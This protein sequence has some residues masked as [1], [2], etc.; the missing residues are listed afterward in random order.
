MHAYIYVYIPLMGG[1]VNAPEWQ[2]YKGSERMHTQA[3]YNKRLPCNGSAGAA[4]AKCT[5]QPAYA[6]VAAQARATCLAVELGRCCTR[7]G[8]GSTDMGCRGL[9]SR[10]MHPAPQ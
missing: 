7:T 3:V 2:G 9:A 1:A 10:Q 5:L 4:C 6:Q 8:S